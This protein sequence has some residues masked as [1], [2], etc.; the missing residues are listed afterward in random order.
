M[1]MTTFVLAAPDSAGRNALTADGTAAGHHLPSNE[2]E[3]GQFGRF[4]TYELVIRGATGNP[5]EWKVEAA[6]KKVTEHSYGPQYAYPEFTP[7]TELETECF[8]RGG[9]AWGKRDTPK[10]SLGK[11]AGVLATVADHTD[12]LGGG[13]NMVVTRTVENFVNRHKLHLLPTFVGGTNPSIKYDLLAHVYG[14]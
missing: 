4:T 13:V 9:V 1:R 10:A 5:T 6:L 14:D 11:N 8:V 2:V 12:G 3:F 7:F